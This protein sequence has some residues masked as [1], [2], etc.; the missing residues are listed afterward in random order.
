[1]ET[2]G[3]KTSFKSK[4]GS[5]KQKSGA[6]QKLIKILLVIVFL[7]LLVSVIRVVRYTKHNL[8]PSTALLPVPTDV[9]EGND[10]TRGQEN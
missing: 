9:L 1:M 5:F 2:E 7:A 10:A 6:K 8:P 3:K 4:D